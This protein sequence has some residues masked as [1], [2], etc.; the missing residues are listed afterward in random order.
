MPIADLLVPPFQNKDEFDTWAFNHNDEHQNIVRA[1]AL[2]GINLNVYPLWPVVDDLSVWEFWHQQMHNQMTA[3]ANVQPTNFGDLS[4]DPK[5]SA[6][7]E[8]YIFNNYQDHLS[9]QSVLDTD[10]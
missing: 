8:F 7:Q 4:F 9:V 1:F 10:D 6:S 2:K 5:N 3:A